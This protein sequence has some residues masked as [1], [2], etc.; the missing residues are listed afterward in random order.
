MSNLVP[1]Y[2]QFNTLLSAIRFDI[3]IVKIQEVVIYV[4]P[5]EVFVTRIKLFNRQ[6]CPWLL[7]FSLLKVM[8]Y[9]QKA[10]TWISKL[11]EQDCVRKSKNLL[12][13]KAQNNALC[14]DTINMQKP[15]E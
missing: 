11:S 4:S 15:Y 1:E 3:H 10:R 8:I 13:S 14:Y 12:S 7:D 5:V 9:V 2:V 6:N